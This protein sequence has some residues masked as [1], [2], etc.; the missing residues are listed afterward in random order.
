L[1]K[2]SHR[3]CIIQ[4]LIDA[5]AGD[6]EKGLVFAGEQVYRIDKIMSVAEIFE[7]FFKGLEFR[8]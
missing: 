2:C 1:K 7:M 5:R 4:S 6:L 8:N 3:F